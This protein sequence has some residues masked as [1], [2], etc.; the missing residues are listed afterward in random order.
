MRTAQNS[1]VLGIRC[2]EIINSPKN[3][4]FEVR[5]PKIRFFGGV[6]RAVLSRIAAPSQLRAGPAR[7]IEKKIESWPARPSSGR[8]SIHGLASKIFGNFPSPSK[9]IEKSTKHIVSSCFMNC[10]RA[11][12][13][14][15]RDARQCRRRRLVLGT[16]HSKRP[17]G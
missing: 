3:N 17:I 9:S 2:F 5:G 13:W 6:D 7:E 15:S 8:A 11:G 12:P 16:Q 1:C 14:P 10:A 4:F